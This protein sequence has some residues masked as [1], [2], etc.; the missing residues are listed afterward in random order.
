[1]ET[2]DAEASIRVFSTCP[3]SSQVDRRDFLARIT[4]VAQWSERYGCKGILIYTDNSI[5][6]PWLVAQQVIRGTQSL[7]PLIAVQ[8]V[9]MHPY[10]VAKMVS[11]IGY[12]HGRRMF[13]N[14][15]AGG[16]KNDLTALCDHTPHDER[17]DRMVEY[18]TIVRRLLEGGSPV[19]F[20]GKYYAIDKLRLAP[21]LPAELFPGIFVSGS[22]DAGLAAA[23]ALGATAIEYPKPPDEY[24][25]GPGGECS[26]EHG[27]RVG[28]IARESKEEAW[29]VAYD[30]F[31]VDR[32]GQLTRQ[33]A[34]K[35]SDSVWHKQLAELGEIRGDNPYW[36]VPF[37]NYKTNCPYLVGSYESVASELTRYI[38]RGFRTF[39]LDILPAEEELCHAGRAFERAGSEVAGG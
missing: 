18:G 19:S 27:L 38:R 25:K 22:S 39:I 11:T 33:L 32:K 24:E 30:R 3:Q 37:Q 29:R 35:V 10:A 28:L 7:C 2:G 12:L 15:V 34:E 36:L 8:P 16:F 5:V 4:D 31:P 20:E 17:Y 21:A 13:L 9:Y 14:M 23:R 26:F 1:M 6:D